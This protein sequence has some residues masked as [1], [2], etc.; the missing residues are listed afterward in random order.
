MPPQVWGR[1]SI[2]LPWVE[3]SVHLPV[4]AWMAKERMREVLAWL[5]QAEVLKGRCSAN[6][7]NG[8]SIVRV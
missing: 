8:F 3:G 5:G 2:A 6:A 4:P 7:L 1:D